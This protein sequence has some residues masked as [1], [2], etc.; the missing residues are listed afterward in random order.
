V[1]VHS[2]RLD[3]DVY[4]DAL[5]MSEVAGITVSELV[6]QALCEYLYKEGNDDGTV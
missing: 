1:R 4:S 6:R 3:D 5:V 2:F